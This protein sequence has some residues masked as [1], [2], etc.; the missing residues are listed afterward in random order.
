M[1]ERLKPPAA[2]FAIALVVSALIVVIYNLTYVDMTGVLTDKLRKGCVTV[3]GEGDY[4]M[5]P[6]I[7][8]ENV[9]SVIRKTDGSGLCFEVTVDGYAKDGL[10]MLVGLDAEGSVTGVYIVSS[11]ETPGLG[12]KVDNSE[13]LGQYT[14]KTGELV[15]VKAAPKSDNEIEGVTGATYSSRGVTNAVNIALAAFPQAKEAIGNE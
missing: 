13:F 2:L 6:E 12:T 14:G 3:L 9:V 5:L 7:Q 11:G 1:K 4:E 10:H 8:L 15:L